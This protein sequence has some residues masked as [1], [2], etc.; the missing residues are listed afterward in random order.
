MSNAKNENN[1]SNASNG[2]N[3]SS[4]GNASKPRNANMS[5]TSVCRHSRYLNA[6][7]SFL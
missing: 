1:A 2:S 4:A 7:Y 3:A 5:S 6:H